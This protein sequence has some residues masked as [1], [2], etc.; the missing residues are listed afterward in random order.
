MEP[1]T[2]RPAQETDLAGLLALYAEAAE[3]NPFK[4]PGSPGEALPV[5]KA[6]L[7]DP[8]RHLCVAAAGSH[9][10]GTADMII[11]ANVA[12]HCM[13]WAVIENVVVTGSARRQGA[14]S[15]MI[16]HLVQIASAAGCYKVQLLSAKHRSAAH[17]LYEKSGFKRLAEGFRLY[18]DRTC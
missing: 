7:A 9:V 18:L 5:F 6:I 14:A 13:P 12:H 10:V 2:V 8:A 3:G 4:A 17:Q 1:I 11:V 15:A 16:R